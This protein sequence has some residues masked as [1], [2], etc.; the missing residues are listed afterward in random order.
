MPADT[1]IDWRRG[2]WL[3]EEHD[4]AASSADKGLRHN[5]P[6]SVVIDT[7]QVIVAPI[8]IRT[9]ITVQQN[10]GDASLI[11]RC[12]HASVDRVLLR[13]QFQWRKKNAGYFLGNQLPARLRCLLLDVRPIPQ[14]TSPK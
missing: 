8:R 14:R 6:S 2:A 4:S 11:E 9:Q 12:S 1:S 3:A 10:N 7:D 5:V 13:G